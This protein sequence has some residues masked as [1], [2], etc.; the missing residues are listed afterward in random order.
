[1]NLDFF[2]FIYLIVLKGILLAQIKEWAIQMFQQ[3][4]SI[5][6][7]NNEAINNKLYLK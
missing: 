7:K 3:A 4:V 2:T 5:D 6:P 1:M